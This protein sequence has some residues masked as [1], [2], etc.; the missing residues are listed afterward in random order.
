MNINQKIQEFLTEH[1]YQKKRRIFTAVLSLMIVFSVVSSLIMPAISMTMQDLDDAAAVDTIDAEPA[2]E[3]IMLLGESAPIDLITSS[4]THEITITDK[5]ANNKD[6]TDNDYN[7]DGNSAN[8]SF[9]IKYTLLK[10]K[11]RFDKN[12]EYD[13][14]IDYDNLNV[15][16]I[17]DGKIFD[18][19]YSINKEAATYT[20]DS[21]EKRIKIKLTQDY[22]DNYVDAEDKTGDLTGSFYFSGTVNRKNDAN[23]D[24]TIKIGGE[25]ITVKFQDKNVSLTK[26][27]WVD[28][29]NNG[30]IVWTINVNP[31]G[32]SLKDYTLVDNM[33][34][35]ASGDVS[36][37]PSNAATYHTDTKQ[38]TFDE[39]NTDNVTITYRTKIGTEDLKNKSVT[40][41][42]TLQ[43]D[44]ENPIEDSKTVTFDK[45]P[46]NVAK[47]GK[48]DYENG[49]S[50]NKKI[51]WTITITSKYGTS[52]NGYQIKDANLPDNG[53][54]ISPSGTL[55]KNGDG[56]WTLNVADNVTG[57]T[58]N[59]SANATDGDN[60][61][62]VSIHY[63]DGSPTDGKA[64]KT[65]NYKKESEMIS[66]N[67]NGNYNQDTHE[68]TWTIQVTPVNGYSLKDYYLEDSQFPSSIDQFTASGCNTS[69]FTISGNRL[70]FT[71]DIKQAVTLQYKTK[72][73]VP[74]ND[75]NAEVTTV[76]TNK[77]EDKFTTT[78]VVSVSV[79]SRNT[80][81]KTVV[82]NSYVSEPTSNAISQEFSWKV[83]ITRDGSFDGYIYQDT[84][85]APENGTH[86]ITADQLAALKVLAKKEYNGNATELV[87][88]TDYKIVKDTNGFHIEFLS[89]TTDY[90]YISF[91]YSTT[92][93]IPESAAYGQYTFNNKGS[94]NKGGGE[95][96]PGVTIEKKNPV[97]TISIGVIKD[98]YDNENSANDRPTSITFKVQ[99]QENNGEWK[100][101]KKSGDTYLFEGDADYS[102]ASVVEVTLNA[103]N[104]VSWSNYRWKT[105]LSGLPSSVTMNGNT[106]TYRYRVQ[107]IKYNGDQAIENGVFSTANGVYRNTGGGYSSPIKANNGE[108]QV[109]NEYH[110]NISLQPV[111]YWK[112]GNNQDITNYTGDITE[113]TV[114]LVS[115]ESDGK[116]YPVK[117]SNGNQ[118]TATLNASNDWGKKLPAWNGLSSEKNYLLIETA[119]KL[120]D[121]TTKNLFSVSDNGTDYNSKEMSFAVDGTYYKATLLGNSVQ[122]TANTTIS[123]TNTVYE[124]K[125]ITVQAKKEWNPSKPDGVSGVVV[126]LQRKASNSNDW[127]AYPEDTTKSQKTLN[128]ANS[129]QAN[130]NDLPNQNVDNTG[131]ISYTYRVV[132]V[133]YVKVDG[134][135]VVSIQNDKFA[136]ANA[137][138]NADGLYEA[139]YVNQ[140]LTKDGTVQI[141]NTYKQ[142]TSIELTPEKKWEGDIDSQTQNP[143]VE[144]PKSIT[145]QLQQKLGENG[146]WV[147]ME[148][149]TLT[150]TKNDQSQYDKSTWK[151]DS[152][153]FENLPEKVIRVNADGSYTEQK[154]YYRLVEINYTPDGSNTA[155]T[156]PDGDTSFDVTGT[157]NNQT[158]NGRYSFSSDENS[159]FSGS[160]KIT[161][162]YREDI[163]VRKNI[164][165]GTSSF[166]D[167]SIQ[168]DELSQFE[169]TIGTEKYYIFNYVVDFSSSQ[170]D[171]ASPISDILP[172]GFE[173][174]C[175][176]SKWAGVQ[177]AW[178]NGSTIN[179][180]TPLTGNPG[181]ISNHFDG[182]YE[183]PV[184]V[185][186]T[187]GINSAKPT[188]LENIWANWGSSEWYYYDRTSNRVYFNRPDLWA[189]MYICYSIKI[190]CEDLEAKIASGNYE[191]VNQVIKHE[192]NGTETDKKDSAS[193]I[194]KNQTPTDLITKTYQS[195]ALPGYISY[196]LDINPQGKTL[197]SGD[198]IDI[199]DL[200]KTVSYY[201]SD[202]NGGETTNGENLVDVL[203]RNINIYKIDAN[204]DKQQLSASEYTLQF[205]CSENGVQSDGEK[206][207]ALLKLTV[208]DATH[209]QVTYSYKIIANKNTPS[210]IHGCKVRKNGRYVPMESGLVPPAGDK[211]TFSNTAKLKA[212]SASGESSHNNQEYTVFQSGGTISTNPIPKI[213]K[214]NTG[215]YTIKSLNASFLLAKYESGNWYYAS[216]VNADGAITWGKQSFNG[217][218]VPATDAYVI[219]VEGTQ[220]KISLEQNVLYKLV[221]IS[222][223]AG[224][225]GSNL[226]LPSGTDFR[227]LVTGYLNSNLTDY[228]G[229]DYTIFLNNYNPNHYFSF[230]SNVSGNNIPHDVSQSEIQQIK[231]GDDLNI[232]NS[233]LI[234]IG[235]QKQWVN[236]TNTIPKNASITVEL[237]WSYEKS[238][239]GIPA[240]A[241]LAKAEDLG[242]LDS[243]FN[244]T[245]TLTKPENAKVWTDL[246][247]G[248]AGKPI[249]YYVKETA[250]T[251]GG[252][253]YTLQEDGSYKDGSDLG[254]YLPIYQ[255]NAA[256]GDA[257]VQIQNTQRLMLK[258]VWKDINNQDMKPLLSSVDVMVY[259]IQ[260][261]S[262]GNET[263]E[264]LFTNPVTLGDTNSWQLDITSLIGN[265]D[266][267]VYKRF[268]VTET[269]VDTS[270]MV[271]SCVFNLNQNTGEIIV[272]NKSTQP[273]DAS[274]T[275][276]KA[277]SDGE[278]LHDAD[279]VSV[280]LYQSTT[281]LPSGTTFSLDWLNKNATKLADKTVTLNKDNDW[282]YTWAE[283]PLKNDSDQP[284][285]YY[286]WEDL[287]NS[288]VVNKDKYTAT[289]TKS[290]NSTAYKTNYT[291]TNSRS[292]ITVQKQWYDED[293][294][295]I[296]NL[297]DED[298]NL[299]VNNM[300]NLKEITLKVYKKTGT[301]PTDSIG[302]V[303]FGDSITDGYGECSRNDK[304]YPSKL[305][306]ML[307]AAGFKLKN[308]A[309][310]NQGQST[311]QIGANK[312]GN[313][314][315]SRVGN[316]PTDTKVVCLLGGTNDI[317]QDYS[318]VKGNPQGV[319]DRLQALIGDIQEQAPNATIFVGSIPHFDFYKDG[320]LT[321][322]GGWWNWLSGYAGNDGAI[323][324]GLIDQY[325]AKIKAYAEKTDGVYFVD[326]CSIVTDDDIRADG[327]HPN[328]AGYTKIATAYSNAI[329]DY[330]TNKEYLKKDNSQ[331][332]LEIKLNNSNNWRAA[333]DV[334]ADNGT[335]CVEE[336]NVPDGWDV[337]YE[338]N[339]QQANSTTPILVKNQKQPTDINLTVEKTWAKDDA[340]NRPDS[341]SLTLL[342]SNGKK[343]DN[344]DAANTSEWFWEELRIPTPTPTK[345]GNKWTFAYTGLPASDAF[346]NA[347]YYK[348]QEAAVSGYTVSYGLNGAGEENGV[349]A[350]AG[351]TATL[352][353]TNTRAITL[354]I[355][356]QW[357]DG[358]TNQHLKDAVRVRIYRSTDQTKVPNA[359]LTLQV[360]PETVSVGV[361]GTAT[362]TA[363]K[364]ITVK[365]I[366]NDTI[367]NATI[368][369]DGKTLTITGKEAGETTITVTDGT[370][371]KKISVTVSV[372]P[373]LN[374][375]IEPASIQVGGTAALTPSMSD[376]SDC[377]GVTYSITKNT[378]VVSISGN[379]VTGSKAGTATIVAERN[380]KTSN[381]VTIIVTELP[382]SL[383]KDN[384]TVSVGD[385]A[386]IQANRTVTIS[387]AP[388][389]SIA[390]ASV[391]GK[392]ITVTGV[393]AGSTSFKVKDS[394]E[395]EKTVLVTVNPK[396]VANG[397]VL[398]GGKTYI[399]EIPADKQENI[400]KLEVSFKDYPTNKS[401]DG[402]DVYFNA[403]NAIDTHPN[404]WIKFN[405]DGSMKDLY[406]FNDDGNYFSKKTRDGYTFGTVSGNTAIW[407]KTTASKNEKIIFRPKDTV[408]SCTI[409]QIKIT[410]EDGTSYTVIDF[411]GGD[412]GGGDTPSTPTQITL[413]ANSTTLKAKETLQLTSNVTGVTYSSSNPQVATV[414]ATTGRVTGVA[415]GSVR[416]TA[417][418]D[419]CTAGTIDLTVEA[420]AKEKVFTIP[421][422]SAGKT[423][424]VT[425]KGTAGT[426]ING[427]FG[428]NDRGS[429]HPTT[430]TWYQWEFGN[431][432]INSDGTLT[433]TH[434]VRNTYTDGDVFFKVWHNNSAVSDITY[435][436]SDSSSSGGESGGG[437]SGGESGETKT[438][439]LKKDT[440]TEIWFKKD[441][442]DVAISS[443]TID[444]KGLT[445]SSNLG[446]NF[447]IGNDQYAA[448]F[449]IGNYGSLSIN[450]VGQH[451]KVSLSG[452]V[453][454]ID[455]FEC[456][457]DRIIFR[458]DAYSLSGDVAI[459]INY[460]TTPQSLSAPRRA[461]AAAAVIESEQLLSAANETAGV[462]T[463][464]LEN[465]IDASE[466]SDSDWASGLLLEIDA[467]DNWQGSVTN[468]PVI[469]SNGN[470][471]YYWAVEEPVT[472]YT[473][474]YLFQ[475]ADGS[476]SNA[477]K[478]DAQV[479]GTD[480]IILNTKQDT[481]Y[482][483]PST[484]GTGVTRYYLIGLLLMGGSGL[485][486]CYQFR[487]KRHGNCAK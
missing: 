171:A 159:G 359:N 205:D 472:G 248:K 21:T 379:T 381:P 94:S 6:I 101:L 231:S 486:V 459:T 318:S 230:N 213:Y 483:L 129:W 17:E 118:L 160:L 197:S 175:D 441:H 322:G 109:I 415:A 264:A 308:N 187:H 42:A 203:M 120:K 152:K 50:R 185:W 66:V 24:Q 302:I 22:I 178:I 119:V 287:Q 40:N 239:S 387:Q 358:A 247:N 481:S 350:T 179:Q 365:E 73:S 32:L 487:R 133:G 300:A 114:V 320:T 127:T 99:Y 473:P 158:F 15:T 202:W 75:T 125:N 193:L 51:D 71:S 425:V 25:E 246:P 374:L 294:N 138:G 389:D 298:G 62:S 113:I 292:A 373:T 188:T 331:D 78:T 60:T 461:V 475:D 8:L 402:V 345:N 123:V 456:N 132:E 336:V 383:D 449:Y 347:Y 145:L 79:K 337:T 326:V 199:E 392:N 20:F 13:L 237:Y 366:A 215:D 77:I 432:T 201:D 447:G 5:D 477:I 204:G 103:E 485:V 225:E 421:G 219:K 82:G 206:G 386:T 191:I 47:D 335:Y 100:V 281:A 117:D 189:K 54:T 130:W 356:K 306:T 186:P 438:V 480:I 351:E 354:Q 167:L 116:F 407:E 422:V 307:T 170:V 151:S 431:Q 34:Q 434:T 349:T 420:D 27:G 344:S 7:K 297:Y 142:L 144:R 28:S 369:E 286:V 92:A 48:A 232:P 411:G 460:A 363:N 214:I 39:N 124:T 394:D 282:S 155:V 70:T 212:D 341:I 12:S 393:A 195:A 325:N 45:T 150:L 43:K 88:D 410:Y 126:E 217:K 412:S 211:I 236:S 52:L 169:K 218:N 238:T 258:K 250:Y 240:S 196:T 234:D 136:L 164:V 262:A 49:K 353:V 439:T 87:K 98:W 137:Q 397:K 409:T 190:K 433:L 284:Y 319:F 406:I 368:S 56:T 149:K 2:E 417:T 445:G 291:I 484:G 382:L 57:V 271:I 390:T 404:S 183:Q 468:L 470:T 139:S 105:T 143:F 385:T 333:I 454:T 474:S 241:T 437:S 448:S 83:D 427:C 452:T 399:F 313:T 81:T 198:T 272:T 403:S 405:D 303:A 436:I 400:K 95:P 69:D 428:Y 266:L 346:G 65:V 61:N 165:V 398:E 46:V 115:K 35:K 280:D 352:H 380:G 254:G 227:A 289:Y 121:G 146:T 86:T 375:A 476:Q 180:Y 423:I 435:T 257:T 102:S 314:F 140:E 285:Y 173:L 464:A 10:M 53:V 233:E 112:D 172:E 371:E 76:V 174:C 370:M 14:Y 97:Q 469:D 147:S 3:N 85:T 251:Y 316:I 192:R 367:A 64:E 482:T 416:I 429:D 256:N 80:I 209:L 462:Q 38:I 89:T 260:V 67:K 327:C 401:N 270:N 355:E 338:N 277:W 90:N 91:E 278:N 16:S 84:L 269:D 443:I 74:D 36:I 309:V 312:E 111:K 108:A 157:K 163:G 479:D 329:Q 255:N 68:I 243:S 259:G 216:N 263:K 442:S 458:S 220:P 323:S 396:Q 414:D 93:T 221:E 304:C 455:N 299:I 446:V 161:N 467:S 424:T 23:G 182:Y 360:T 342:Q 31:N 226:N 106:K 222:V 156:I 293:G 207:A 391:S 104:K 96:N 310:D 200:F 244:A 148:G 288:T 55:T 9:F 453:F 37:N 33:L 408:K 224:Y 30:D 110:P 330:Y 176:D 450:Q 4:S 1:Q 235:V 430:P 265:K 153:K 418:K 128:D 252:N 276:Q 451:C 41:K 229:Q 378:D 361:N 18:P 471:Y 377:S 194:I 11:N 332:D 362:V 283:L 184:F 268:E 301:V 395:N 340:S 26:N 210:V 168:K 44:G 478:A 135:T 134:T 107:E 426:T 457:L 305:T 279:T 223:P 72:V 261:D 465:T 273:T 357:S 321:T 228:N 466:V 324:N 339:A 162:T 384:V 376:G 463:Q 334:P 372:E 419:G 413:T 208:P 63:P 348:V 59:Y 315:S 388:V 58:L 295:L 177:L 29:A 249:Y 444:A 440:S 328:E 245:K 343:Q 364:K 290:S 253:T 141:T 166:E 181:N 274:V 311:Q 122:P 154:Y 317:H 296:T 267:S 19:D 275:V 131:R 242:I